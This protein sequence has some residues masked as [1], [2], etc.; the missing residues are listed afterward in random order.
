MYVLVLLVATGLLVGGAQTSC[1]H[2]TLL[3]SGKKCVSK[4]FKM[5]RQEPQGNCRQVKIISLRD[6]LSG[7]KV[8]K[9]D[10]LFGDKTFIWTLVYSFV[11]DCF[12]S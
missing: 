10:L 12:S 8:I 11:T 7:M 4:F 3:D 9:V 2:S 5:N 1:T 6:M